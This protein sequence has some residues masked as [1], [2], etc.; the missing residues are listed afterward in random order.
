[1]SNTSDFALTIHEQRQR[2]ERAQVEQMRKR[3]VELS[4]D[5]RKALIVERIQKPEPLA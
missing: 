3:D 2:R 1:M 4:E 5:A